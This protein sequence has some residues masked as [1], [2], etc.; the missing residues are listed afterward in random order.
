MEIV[1]D[2]TQA[3]HNLPVTQAQ[4]PTVFRF[5]AVIFGDVNGDARIDGVDKITVAAIS[6]G[7]AGSDVTEAEMIAADVDN[8]GVVDNSDAAALELV[9]GS[10]EATINQ[11]ETVEGS[12]VIMK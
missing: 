10:Y 2:N 6:N 5:T 8:N 1:F 11:A 7:V 9:Y 3:A 4:I 12:R